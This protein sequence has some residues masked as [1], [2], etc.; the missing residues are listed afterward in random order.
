MKIQFSLLCPKVKNW[1]ILYG[2]DELI[3]NAFKTDGCCHILW[4]PMAKHLTFG[5]GN[6][7]PFH[8]F[9][10]HHQSISFNEWMTIINFTQSSS[11]RGIKISCPCYQTLSFFKLIFFFWSN[12]TPTL[13]AAPGLL[14]YFHPLPLSKGNDPI[15]VRFCT[16]FRSSII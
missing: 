14:Q 8:P 7:S 3:F 1:Q 9:W 16:I 11:E 6:S 15:L 10:S 13:T 2:S 5:T 4:H 12:S